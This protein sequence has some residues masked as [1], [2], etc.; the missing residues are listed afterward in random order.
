MW[1]AS[2]RIVAYVSASAVGSDV[3]KCQQT[4]GKESQKFLAT[5]TKTIAKCWDARIKG[6][7]GAT[8]PDAAAVEGSPARKAADQIASAENK[9]REKI[10]KACGGVDGLCDGNGDL[11]LAAIGAAPS[12]P[13]VT[14]PGGASCGGTL[15]TL[16]DLVDCALC[17]TEFGVDC[18]DRAQVPGLM[19][20]PVDC[21]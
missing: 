14:V 7:H 21:N 10:C 20:Y 1:R 11:A 17:V 18:A 13:T 9:A 6:K 4:I 3:N 8:C 16:D 12:C 15:S 19:A 2:A 5:K